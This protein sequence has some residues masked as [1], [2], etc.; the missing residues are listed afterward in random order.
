M[1]LN[2]F[3]NHIK[4]TRRLQYYLRTIKR[5]LLLTKYDNL[6]IQVCQNLSFMSSN[7]SLQTNQTK[8]V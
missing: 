5:R 1:S 2:I 7:K 6:D 4:K 3:M 8:I